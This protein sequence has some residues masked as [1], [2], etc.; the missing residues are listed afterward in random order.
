VSEKPAVGADQVGNSIFG[1]ERPFRTVSLSPSMTEI[2]G[3]LNAVSTLVGTDKYSNYPYSVT[4]G[5]AKGDIAIVGDYVNPS[6]E[7]I[8]GADPDMVYCDGS[9]YIHYEMSERLRRANVPAVV[10]Y[11][12]E[13]TETIIDNIYIMGVTLQY[14]MA[15][16]GVITM[17]KEAEEY[18]TMMLMSGGTDFVR[19]MFALSPDKSPWV[20]GQYTYMDDISTAV[21]GENSMAMFFGWAH[22]SSEVIASA[23]P[24]VVVILAETYVASPSEY[25]G[26][27]GQMS[28]E[29]KST[30]AYKNGKIYIFC[31]ELGEMA[32][33]PGPRYMQIM[34]L[35][36]MILHPDMFAQELPKYIG[37]EYGSYLTITKDLGFNN[38]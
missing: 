36:A 19:T 26:M 31:G 34:E 1:Y 27:I 22:I 4:E 15:A 33:R 37:N 28:A 16:Q 17:L 25:D 24:S 29:W 18:L 20:A 3:A 23:N 38:E 30:D 13:S 5:Q 7:M 21:F 11:A 10:L 6:F 9:Q 2:M 8:M 35:F 32:S 14:E 12:G